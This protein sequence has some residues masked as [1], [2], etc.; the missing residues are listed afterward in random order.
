MILTRRQM[1]ADGALLLA[2]TAGMLGAL[3]AWTDS[4]VRIVGGLLL[5]LFTPG[6]ALLKALFPRGL[7]AVERN[8]L[9][10]PASFV[11]AILIGA[12]VDQ[13]P[14]GLSGS[15]IVA[16]LWMCTV[17]L[18]MVAYAR[19]LRN[20]MPRTIQISRLSL[21]MGVGTVVVSLLLVEASLI[22][23]GASLVEASLSTPKAFTA[24]SVDGARGVQQSGVPLSVTLD[25]EEGQPMRYDLEVDAG[26]TAVSR[27]E[28]VQ[29]TSGA[30]YSMQLPV[31]ADDD[32]A[33]A[34]V[35]AYRAGETT[36]Y[37][38]VHVGPA[39]QS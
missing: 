39:A 21:P 17:S 30:H 19:S 15:L 16:L 35:I 32:T 7:T 13:T 38:Q 29:L 22:W 18:M 11:V 34:D 1:F 27:V 31:L 5:A 36:P 24:L 14:Y 28:G 25:N 8:A 6:Y 3:L 33:G 2:A 9:S 23:A 26:G 20:R 4:P 12:A 37:R 10:V